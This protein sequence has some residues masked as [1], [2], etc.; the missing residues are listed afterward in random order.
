MPGGTIDACADA[1]PALAAEHQPGIALGK[2]LDRLYAVAKLCTLLPD[3]DPG[4]GRRM[5]A[6]VV[7]G[8]Q[9]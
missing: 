1:A 7:A 2:W 6:L 8:L 9:R 4:Y 3:E 5:V